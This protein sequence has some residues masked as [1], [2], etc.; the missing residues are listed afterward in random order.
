MLEDP[1]TGRCNS[2]HRHL[3]LELSLAQVG[4]SFAAQL[5]AQFFS[6][7]ESRPLNLKN[8]TSKFYPLRGAATKSEKLNLNPGH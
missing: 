2:N 8:D 1:E 5:P 7:S 4:T 6:K 3:N